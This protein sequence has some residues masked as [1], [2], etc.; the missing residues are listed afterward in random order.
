MTLGEL[1][2]A[3]LYSMECAEHITA[4]SS[5]QAKTNA[6]SFGCCFAEVEVDIPLGKV[7]LLN[8]VNAH[9]CGT[10]INPRL[11]EAQV[12]GGMSMGIGYALSEQMLYDEK[13][14]ALLNGNFLDYKL[15][16]IMDTP[17]LDVRFVENPEPTS[18]FGTKA[19]GEPPA[20]PG[21]AAIR[22]ALLHATGVRVNR[23]PLTPHVLIPAFK[24]ARLL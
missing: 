6:Y 14:G 7:K 17:H 18:P 12:H 1:A 22:N 16:T 9:D 8:I 19:L 24:D 5:A 20:V 15:G 23:I 4:E 2:T 21:G 13:T 11:A 10:L 3:R